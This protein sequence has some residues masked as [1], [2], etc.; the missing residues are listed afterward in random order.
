MIKPEPII[1]A[2]A[3]QVE[4]EEA[5]KNKFNPKDRFKCMTCTISFSNK[6]KYTKHVKSKGHKVMENS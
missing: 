3:A 6:L 5:N 1:A 4:E 2:Q